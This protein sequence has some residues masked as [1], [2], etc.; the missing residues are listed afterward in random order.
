MDIDI[1][2]EDGCGYIYSCGCGSSKEEARRN[3]NKDLRL[4]K[5]ECRLHIGQNS[6]VLCR[7]E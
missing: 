5:T 3:H 4:D 6:N 7:D 2:I 1:Y